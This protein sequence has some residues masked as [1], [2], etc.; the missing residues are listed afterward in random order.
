M[1][2]LLATVLL[3]SIAGCG[4]DELSGRFPA[5]YGSFGNE[6]RPPTDYYRAL[7]VTRFNTNDTTVT[8]DRKVFLNF[9]GGE[10]YKGFDKNQSF[11]LCN[12][13]ITIN[14]AALTVR[15]QEEVFDEVKK[16]FSVADAPL[17][18]VLDEPLTGD[19]STVHIGGEHHALG[20]QSQ[21]VLGIAPSDQGD[22]NP[23]DVGFVFSNMR[24][25][26]PHAIAHVVGRVSGLPLQNNARDTVMARHISNHTP[27]VLR[28]QERQI[29]RTQHTAAARVASDK[30]PGE[31]FISTI[32]AMLGE[33]DKDE[34]LDIGPLQEELRTIVPTTVKLP[35][36]AR[37][38]SVIHILGL[39]QESLKQNGKWGT[40][41]NILGK[42]LKNTI[43]K[44]VQKP[45]A[46]RNNVSTS[47]ADA[48]GDAWQK[49]KSA[50][51]QD[52]RLTRLP[53]LA[54]LLELDTLH[55]S[56]QL[57]PLLH[58]QRQLLARTVDGTEHDSM[59]SLLK[60]GY[61]QQLAAKE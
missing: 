50:S 51:K 7:L 49:N 54:R 45:R 47:I 24:E 9:G 55:E 5:A 34:M 42:V 53:D 6:M 2:V 14:P 15:E 48:L 52:R 61:F 39:D 59:L 43:I 17:S 18:L 29:L 28:A 8:S 33:L 41:K 57:F 23:A 20:C 10:I 3:F 30:L 11:I 1:Q 58:A 32:S 27:L 37:A 46:V 4:A 36:L 44:S 12:E 31:T 16:L 25:L 60:V 26:L 38:L 56:A 35:A 19:Y 21:P 22:V 40:L 13:A